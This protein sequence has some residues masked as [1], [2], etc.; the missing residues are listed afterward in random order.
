M[1]YRFIWKSVGL[2]GVAAALTGC[3]WGRP[4]VAGAENAVSAK[5]SKGSAW[6]QSPQKHN[7][8]GLAMRYQ[9]QGGLAVG[10]PVTVVLEFSGALGNDAHAI[11]NPAKTLIVGNIGG[12]QK[13]GD[14]YRVALGT[15]DVSTQ[16]FTVTPTSEDAHFISIQLNQNGQSS[17]AGIMLRMGQKR[18]KNEAPGPVVTGANG[19]KLIVMPAR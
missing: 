2:I 18:A 4:L 1:F 6:V 19:E 8:S 7:N 14:S 17:A 15:V 5:S 3:D 11:V 9:V 10:Q 16:A 13:N 12:M